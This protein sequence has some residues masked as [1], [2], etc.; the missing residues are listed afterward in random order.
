MLNIPPFS[1]PSTSYYSFIASLASNAS[2]T[3][4]YVVKLYSPPGI[5]S[6]QN[7]VTDCSLFNSLTDGSE[8]DEEA[9]YNSLSS[10]RFVI[11]LNKSTVGV[12][13]QVGLYRLDNPLV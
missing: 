10:H 5:S 2:L 1:V 8:V 11:L 4:N 3:N 7:I 9:I 13:F 6:P 12:G